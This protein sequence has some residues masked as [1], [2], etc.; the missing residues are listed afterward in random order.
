MILMKDPKILK[1]PISSQLSH[2]CYFELFKNILGPRSVF[3]FIIH[4]GI[5]VTTSLYSILKYIM[6][7]AENNEMLLIMPTIIVQLLLTWRTTLAISILSS[8]VRS[9]AIFIR[10]GGWLWSLF[11]AAT[12][13][14]YIIWL[15]S[16]DILMVAE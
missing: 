16:F 10:M 13:Y 8:S 6:K 1:S 15:T 9:G 3:R 4:N 12:T 5:T 2:V 14:K 7:M 11:L